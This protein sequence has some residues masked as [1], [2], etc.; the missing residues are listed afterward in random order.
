MTEPLTWT[1][2]DLTT[3]DARADAIGF[4]REV[5]RKNGENDLRHDLEWALLGDADAR[6]LIAFR[7]DNGEGILGFALL[8]R[9]SR[10]LHFQLGKLTYYQRRLTRYDLQTAPLIA[11]VAKESE[12][13]QEAARNFIDAVRRHLSPSSEA[14]AIEGVQIDSPFH[15]LLHHDPRVKRDFLLI[16]QG[17]PFEHHFILMPATSDAYLNDLD[18]GSKESLAYHRK[19]ILRDFADDVEVTCFERESDVQ[20][21]LDLAMVISMNNCQ[22]L[23]LGLGL[24]ERT[25]LEARLRFAA[26][27]KWLRGYILVCSG[28]PVAFMLGYQRDR[29]FYQ[30]GIGFDPDYRQWSV[31]SILQAEVIEDLDA[32]EQRPELFDFLTNFGDQKVRFNNR[33]RKEIDILLLPRTLRHAILASAYQRLDGLADLALSA[34]DR[35]GVRK[36]LQTTF[37]KLSPSKVTNS[38]S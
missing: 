31:G 33:E 35:I 9:Q 19:R 26:A 21:F 36:T 25:P 1:P 7:M 16:K 28:R 11:G 2:I 8:L 6:S 12:A 10:P 37:Q 18:Q 23:R 17:K 32:R 24:E 27:R 22:G 14:L 13:W 20:A 3:E 34:V 29:C 4:A 38:S 30:A 15:Q 5:Q